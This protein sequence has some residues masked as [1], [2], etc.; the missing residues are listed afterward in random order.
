MST[1]QILITQHWELLFSTSATNF[2]LD[3]GLKWFERTVVI[4]NVNALLQQHN[5]NNFTQKSF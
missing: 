2:Q 4:E 1:A 3:I 5:N